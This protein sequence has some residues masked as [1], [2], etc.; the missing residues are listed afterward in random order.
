MWS[1]WDCSAPC[2][3]DW[4]TC[5]SRWPGT[6]AGACDP[7]GTAVLPVTE[8]GGRVTAGGQGR[9]L[10]HVVLLGLQCSL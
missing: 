8:T 7:P 6:E 1:S 3:G 5:Y 10:G 9:R 2:D 4:G